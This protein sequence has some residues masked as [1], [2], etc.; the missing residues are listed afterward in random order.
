VIP[1]RTLLL[2]DDS[3]AIQKVIDLTFTDEGM[4]VITAGDGRVALE[5]LNHSKPDVV[6][7]DV[8]M[9]GIDGY[10]LCKIIKQNERLRGIPVMLLVGSFEPFDEAEAKRAGADDVV[11]KPFQSIRDLVSRV[12]LLVNRAQLPN[13]QAVADDE[14]TAA[15]EA[16]ENHQT[17][18]V[19]DEVMAHMPESEV[20]DQTSPKVFVE[21][22]VMETSDIGA[23]PQ[24]TCPPDIE[25][26]TADTQQ[27]EPVIGAKEGDS[28]NV[29]VEIVPEAQS[30]EAVESGDVVTVGEFQ[31]HEL[32]S[33]EIDA[34]PVFDDEGVLDLGDV[35][36]FAGANVADDFEL[37]VDVAP[38]QLDSDSTQTSNISSGML[39]TESPDAATIGDT[40]SVAEETHESVETERMNE[41]GQ[42]DLSPAAIEAISRRVVEQL[43]DKVVREIAWEVVPELSELLIKKRLED[44]R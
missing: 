18:P 5:K 44:Q 33:E 11:T 7:A 16:S 25:L 31:P 30:A 15:V 43:S 17:P 8:F 38:V 23:A 24:H 29:E 32:V 10:E 28:E 9:P 1:G 27:L 41:P 39:I 19:N 6:L 34:A 13:Q 3:V 26:Q 35:D 21:A 22:G 36:S 42:T 20:L 12:G 14:S 40:V 37:D 2:A 4:Q